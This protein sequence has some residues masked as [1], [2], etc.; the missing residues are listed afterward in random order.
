MARTW[1][2]SRSVLGSRPQH[3]YPF[4]AGS[5]M[6]WVEGAMESQA[7]D[8]L[9]LRVERLERECRLWRKASAA[10]LL[11]LIILFFS[12]ATPLSTGELRVERLIVQDKDDDRKGIILRAQD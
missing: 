4:D 1:N 8:M 12:G 10:T 11:G 9:S 2:C 3:I 6:E 7:F 5:P